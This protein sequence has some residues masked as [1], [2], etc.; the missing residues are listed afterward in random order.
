MGP[1]YPLTKQLYENYIKPHED[2]IK[3][4]NE[5]RDKNY[6]IE[7]KYNVISGD[8]PKWLMQTPI[9]QKIR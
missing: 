6:E 7:D 5:I 4:L 2:K 1:L 8:I 9:E 3:K